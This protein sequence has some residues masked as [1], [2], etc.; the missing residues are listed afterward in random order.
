MNVITI[1]D[2]KNNQIKKHNDIIQ[3]TGALSGTAFKMLSM[4]VSMVRTD[5]SDFQEYAL[6]IEDYKKEIGV[7]NKEVSFYEKQALELMRNPFEVKKGVWFNWC[8]KVDV[9]SMN[10]Y[11]IFK[12]DN[13]LKPYL[14]RLQKNFTTYNL[15][16]IMKLRGDYTPRLYEYF[17]MKWNEYKAYNKDKKSYTFDL[18]IDWL[19]EHFGIPNGYRY[20]NIKT[21]IIEVAKKQFK[22]KTDI[23]FK[24]TEQKIGRRVDRII[25]TIRDNDKGFN[26]Y[27]K[28]L[29]AFISFYR[30]NKVN[31]DL[32]DDG[33]V[34]IS[35]GKN[36]RLYDKYTAQEY[37]KNQAMI[38][39]K[40]LYERAKN[41]Q[42]DFPV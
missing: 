27:L 26:D 29:K 34:C 28:D 11:I 14:L 39:W 1:K 13:D 6:R 35:V 24:Y 12:I 30:K 31:E 17:I 38:V 9:A 8:S 2:N 5:D 23:Q 22:E 16:N 3:A 33:K 7:T 10:G 40:K 42:L 19:R 32:F 15:T 36:G 20:N 37:D 21:Q 25:I 41:N 4:L 18:K